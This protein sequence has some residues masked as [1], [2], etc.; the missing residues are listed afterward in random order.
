MLAHLNGLVVIA[1]GCMVLVYNHRWLKAFLF[2]AIASIVF[3]IT[4]FSDVLLLADFQYFFN[5]FTHDPA[6]DASHF[7]WYS[8]FLKIP[9]EFIRYFHAD[10]NSVFSVPFF[11][12][13]I[14][15]FKYLWKSSRNMMVYLL[16]IMI[17]ISFYT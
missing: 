17:I 15:T 11:V 4:Y 9:R 16:T 13:F 7:H 3:F 10:V 6:L 12:V 1:A 8:P 2:G 5:Q 14:L